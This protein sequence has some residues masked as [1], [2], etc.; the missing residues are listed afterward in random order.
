MEEPMFQGEKDYYVPVLR[1]VAGMPN[2]A[3]RKKDVL[4]ELMRRYGHRIPPEHRE[5]VSSSIRTLKWDNYASWSRQHLIEAGYLDAPDRGVWGITE[6]GRRWVADH[7]HD[8]H[9]KLTRRQSDTPPNRKTR[10][11]KKTDVV[12]PAG[13]SLDM[14]EKTRQAMGDEQFRPVWGELYDHLIAA[15]RAAMISDID[16]TKLT[17][18]LRRQIREIHNYLLG[19]DANRPTSEQICDWI[20]FCYQ[21]SLYREAAALFA[22]VNADE[23]NPWYLERTR[24]IAVT[25]RAKL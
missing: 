7:P 20:H 3:A 14:L 17:K 21:F 11:K 4:N 2:G 19:R 1:V 16:E 13:L 5:M 6:M 12:L 18:L 9:I 23:V 10:A 24:R 25:S 8:S 22:T 15:K